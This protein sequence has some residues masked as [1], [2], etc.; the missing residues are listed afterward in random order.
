MTSF[1]VIILS[2]LT[3]IFGALLWLIISIRLVVREYQSRA[4]M[5]AELKQFQ[6]K[7]EKIEEAYR[8]QLVSFETVNNFKKAL[9]AME[10]KFKDHNLY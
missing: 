3:A 4:E 5:L 8:K 2:I 7:V 10:Q 9:S 1:Q 6:A